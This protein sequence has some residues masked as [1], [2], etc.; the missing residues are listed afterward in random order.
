MTTPRV[1]GSHRHSR[2]LLRPMKRARSLRTPLS[3]VSTAARSLGCTLREVATSSQPE[4]CPG[5]G[6]TGT[7]SPRSPSRVP[8][9]SSSRQRT[10]PAGNR[11]TRL[12]MG[13]AL[14]PTPS[15]TATR[16]G[17]ASGTH[18]AHSPP[19]GRAHRNPAARTGLLRDSL[20]HEPGLHARLWVGRAPQPAD[21]ASTDQPE[22]TSVGFVERLVRVEP[23][24]SAPHDHSEILSI[25]GDLDVDRLTALTVAHRVGDE[26]AQEQYRPP[27]QPA[28]GICRPSTT[29]TN[30]RGR[31][32]RGRR[33]SH[34]LRLRVGPAPPPA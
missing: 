21:R 1:P 7:T 14:R 22:P 23:S 28:G 26:L 15:S 27:S 2:K 17:S 32:R 6:P 5:T 19:R 16:S 12:V 30:G 33:V 8:P 29:G 25:E 24:A 18:P 34:P 3:R 10:A 13:S 31:A 20:N 4:A 9:R 11:C